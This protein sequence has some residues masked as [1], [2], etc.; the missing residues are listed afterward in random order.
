MSLRGACWSLRGNAEVRSGSLRAFF[1]F[2]AARA[3]HMCFGR[4]YGL[5]TW[6]VP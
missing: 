6:L 2:G 4:L 5:P 3:R 1:P